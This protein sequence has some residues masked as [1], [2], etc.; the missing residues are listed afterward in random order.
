MYQAGLVLEGGGMKGIYTAGVLDYFLEKGIEFSACY[1]VSAGA[2]HMSNF[3]SKQK[4]R[5]LRTGINYLDDK[6]YCSF[7]SLMK[8]GD[9]FNVDFC[10]RKIPFELDPLDN[11]TFMKYEGKAYAVITNIITGKPEYYQIKDLVKD[12]VAIRAS[13]SLPLLSKNVEINGVPYLD[14]GI[15]DSVPIRKSIADGNRKNVVVLTKEEGFVRK[16][17]SHRGLVKLMYRKYPQVGRLMENRHIEYNEMMQFLEAEERAGR[18]FVIRP[19]K[20]LEIGRI[21]KDADKMRKAYRIG[22]EDAKRSYEQ[23]KAYLDTP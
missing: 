9:F 2:I 21:E 19:K 7:A 5:G 1:G 15:S 3:V 20:T 6:N 18:V 23:M 22:Y 8:T 14:G 16:P 12:I 10:Y 11:E 4:E 13:S 17:S